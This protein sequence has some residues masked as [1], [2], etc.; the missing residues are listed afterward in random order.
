MCGETLTVK[1][2]VLPSEGGLQ[3]A[4]V[5]FQQSLQ[6]PAA[7]HGQVLL[8][9]AGAAGVTLGTDAKVLPYQQDRRRQRKE[10]EMK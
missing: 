3:R 5:V 8:H 2:L 10:E 1:L 7:Q 4:A 6:L 9:V